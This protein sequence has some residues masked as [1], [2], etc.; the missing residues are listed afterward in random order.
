MSD[1]TSLGGSSDRDNVQHEFM[2]AGAEDIRLPYS[3]AEDGPEP[4]DEIGKPRSLW[5]DAWADLRRNKLFIVGS[6]LVLLLI[7]MAAFP[8][9]F[10]N[11]DPRDCSLSNSRLPPSGDAWF[12]Y[13][14]QGCDVY[15]RTIYG[16]R[17][18]ILVGIF[19][20][21]AVMIIGGVIGIV[22]GFF[23]GW[24]DGIAS[25]ITDV[26]L[27][28]PL[29]LGSIL[30][31]TAFPSDS[32]TP[33]LVVIGKVV[34]A[35]AV[36]GWTQLARIMRSS[37][38]QV[39]NQDY[40]QAARALGANSTRIIGRHVLPNSLAPVIVVAMISLGAYISAEATLSFLGIGLQPPVISWGIAINDAATYVRTSPHMLLFPAAFLSITVFA[41]IMLGDAVRDALDPKLR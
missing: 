27:A 39:K 6:I 2:R 12:G 24:A 7:V 9:L 29:L 38:I 41:F 33:E 32:D 26:F 8:Q 5:Q 16:A 13:D 31:L 4:V 10:T 23:G 22:A 28:L 35:L 25:R 30:I 15:S 19:T 37:V 3:S 21:T 40:V 14:L 18:S 36:L 20:T 34:V 1:P 11:I 17:A